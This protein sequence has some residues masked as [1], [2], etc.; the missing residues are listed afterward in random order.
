MQVFNSEGSKS[1]DFLDSWSN[2]E[3]NA[4]IKAADLANALKKTASAGKEA[5][6][7][8]HQLNGIVATIGSVTRQTG[9]EIGTSTRFMLSRLTGE[10]APAELKTRYLYYRSRRKP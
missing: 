6:F 4:A 7:T 9:N 5:G 8:F 2:V 10:K 3:S 1:I